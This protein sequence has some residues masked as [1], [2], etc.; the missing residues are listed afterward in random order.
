MSESTTTPQDQQPVNPLFTLLGDMK[1]DVNG[2]LQD[3]INLVRK[4]AKDKLVTKRAGDLAVSLENYMA[5]DRAYRAIKEDQI[6]HN[7][8]GTVASAFFSKAKL[9]E[10]QK[11]KEAVEK[12]QKA[13][14]LALEKGDFSQLANIKAPGKSS[15]PATDEPAG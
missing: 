12:A 6:N 7:G 2:C 1:S 4:N 15:E 9:T 11:A 10:K 5:L 13:L 3:V 8:D 14:I